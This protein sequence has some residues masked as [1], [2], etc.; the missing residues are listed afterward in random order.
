MIIPADMIC[1]S[2]GHR[3]PR[4][5]LLLATWAMDALHLKSVHHPAVR[6][7]LVNVHRHYMN[8][9]LVSL[10][11]GSLYQS[12]PSPLANDATPEALLR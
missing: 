12:S 7:W 11:I 5:P 3:L 1:L 2:G 8:D 9:S 6:T 10:L 4:M